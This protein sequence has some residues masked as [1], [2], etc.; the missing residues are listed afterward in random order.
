MFNVLYSPIYTLPARGSV[1]VDFQIRGNFVDLDYN[2]NGTTPLH[3][4]DWWGWEISVDGEA[5][6]NM[7]NPYSDPT[8]RNYVVADVT[9]TW[10]WASASYGHVF[11]TDIS[12]YIGRQVQFRW[13]FSSDE[14]PPIGEGIMIDDFTIYNTMPL[15]AARELTVDFNNDGDVELSWKGP[16]D[17]NDVEEG[18]MAHG[19]GE[20]NND[21]SFGG[22][23][24]TITVAQRFN[25]NHLREMNKADGL[26]TK[27]AFML[28]APVDEVT[29][30]VWT[31]G[32]SLTNAGMLMAE[33]TY[34]GDLVIG[35]WNEIVLDTPVSIPILSELRIGY[36]ISGYDGFPIALDTAPRVT[37]YGNIFF[38]RASWRT[39]DTGGNNW[40]IRGYV[41][42]KPEPSYARSTRDELMPTGF[43]I[44]RRTASAGEFIKIGEAGADERN[45]VD[46]NPIQAAI[47]F[48]SVTVLYT[49]DESQRSNVSQ[50]FIPS[51][52]MYLLSHDN[53][54]MNTARAGSFTSLNRFELQKDER[55]M[56]HQISH[57][58]V[59]F[60]RVSGS[61]TLRVFSELGNSPN[62]IY[63]LL[64]PAASIGAGWNT[65]ALPRVSDLVIQDGH[66]YIGFHATA[67]AAARIGTDTD[68]V[69]DNLSFSAQGNSDIFTPFTTGTFMIRAYMDRNVG[70]NDV[71]DI[72]AILTA[73]NFP[74]PFNPE[75]TISFN[76]PRSGHVSVQVF[77]VRGQ[78]VN[79]LLH[80]EVEAG[81]QSLIW[82]G[83]D[84][85]GNR[86]SSGVY[87][88][89]I[90][91]QNESLVNK[92]L[93]MK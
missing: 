43:N 53:G 19:N 27:V 29:V 45:F 47:N 76:M 25:S 66:F 52:T 91:T 88:Y 28:T 85:S 69:G 11:V 4:I 1:R 8:G 37:D 36:E 73:N 83:L 35:Q 23:G 68:T 46:P 55:N 64:I 60:E 14:D 12:R 26:L 9:P 92:M 78:L 67:G 70:E 81:R 84:N 56:G 33:Q 10:T 57:V 62:M 21:V 59:F 30:R 90:Q 31:G 51:D 24:E 61:V 80:D 40:A 18:W 34:T 48:Y 3:M 2:P 65:I 54:T 6:L 39:E 71:V 32:S 75:T 49:D 20:F 44:Y 7:S 89:R 5:W 93:L 58:Q 42:P 79:T 22:S 50:F 13:T 16:L 87:F 82:T 63:S 41:V 86:V 38:S 15:H 72:P 77:N 17:I 74:N